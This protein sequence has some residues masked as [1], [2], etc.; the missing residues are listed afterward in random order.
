[1]FSLFFFK[2]TDYE[3]INCDFEDGFCFW[4]QDLNDDNE[5][6]RVQGST[7][8][9]FTGPDFDHTYGNVSGIIHI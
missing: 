4:V 5:W 6:E 2:F 7:F 1:M 3:K 9:P 8:P